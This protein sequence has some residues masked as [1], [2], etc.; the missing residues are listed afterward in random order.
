MYVRVYAL[1]KTQY[2][3]LKSLVQ[4]QTFWQTFNLQHFVFGVRIFAKTT[5]LTN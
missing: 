4:N 5:T 2:A 3:I 1:F